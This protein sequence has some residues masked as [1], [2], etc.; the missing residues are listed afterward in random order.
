MS[1]REYEIVTQGGI[2]TVH[3]RQWLDP[4]DPRDGRWAVVAHFEH[5]YPELA[6]KQYVG[7][8]LYRQSLLEGIR[9]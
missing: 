2:A 1:D 5:E 7:E 4:S 8:V 3:A 9:G 6:A